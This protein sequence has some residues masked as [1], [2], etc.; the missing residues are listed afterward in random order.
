[1]GIINKFAILESVKEGEE[2]DY[3]ASDIEESIE[4]EGGGGMRKSRAAS[5][6]VAELMKALL[7]QGRKAMLRG[8]SSRLR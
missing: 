3:I 5:V 7:N 6:G 1:M 8:K 4:E 2:A